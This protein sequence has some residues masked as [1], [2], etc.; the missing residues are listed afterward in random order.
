MSLSGSVALWEKKTPGNEK[1]EGIVLKLSIM[2]PAVLQECNVRLVDCLSHPGAYTTHNATGP[3]CDITGDTYQM[4]R[5]FFWSH[6]RLYTTRL[7]HYMSV[8]LR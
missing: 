1:E 2:S 7:T 3:L 6:K 4:T 5:S 8:C